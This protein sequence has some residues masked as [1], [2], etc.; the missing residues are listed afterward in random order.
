M[1]YEHEIPSGSKLYFGKSAKLKREIENVVSD[2]LSKEG[3]EEIVTPFFSY[4]QHNNLEEKKLIRFSNE[5]NHILSLRADSTMDVVRLITKRLGRSTT[6][7][8]W[9]YIQ[10]IFRYPSN[11]FYQIGV[12]RIGDIDLKELI[13]NIENIMKK[14][15]LTP[16]LQISNINIPKIISKNYDIDIEIFKTAH[17]ERILT[18]PIK[19][20]HKLAFLQKREQIEEIIKEVP[21][22]IKKEILKMAE[23]SENISCKNIV[24]AP[25]Y[26]SEMTYYDDLFFRFFTNN[27]TLGKGGIYK[28]EGIHSSGFALYTDNII[29]EL[30]SQGQK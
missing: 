17:L 30:I 10:P 15:S 6:H 23:L 14:L 3:Y 11:E 27:K 2:I 8:K 7:K 1:I 22:E 5:T 26:Y 16:I 19:W 4:H 29:E 21:A 24:F 25:L 28:S 13:L 18:S 20:L 9:F 12:E